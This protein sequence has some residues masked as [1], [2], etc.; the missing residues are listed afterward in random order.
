MNGLCYDWDGLAVYVC[1]VVIVIDA[2]IEG[3]GVGS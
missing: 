2:G 3:T 1:V